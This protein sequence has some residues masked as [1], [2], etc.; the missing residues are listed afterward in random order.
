MAKIDKWKWFFGEQKN[1]KKEKK[2]SCRMIEKIGKSY[3]RKERDKRTQWK[4]KNEWLKE[5]KLGAS[6]LS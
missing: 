6:L 4:D 1:K 2:K 3:L 5:D